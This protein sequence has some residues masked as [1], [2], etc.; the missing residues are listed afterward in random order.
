MGSEE[1]VGASSEPPGDGNS[2][3][4]SGDKAGGSGGED[5]GGKGSNAGAAEMVEVGRLS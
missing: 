3:V 5:E 1:S 4:M 2:G